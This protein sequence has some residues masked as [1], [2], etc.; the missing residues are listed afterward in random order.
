MFEKITQLS[1]I[2][3]LKELHYNQQLHLKGQLRTRKF[4]KH[5]LTKHVQTHILRTGK[6]RKYHHSIFHFLKLKC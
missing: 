3:N 2:R 4:L 5:E 1:R 6:I